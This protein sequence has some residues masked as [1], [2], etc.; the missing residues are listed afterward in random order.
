LL[1]LLPEALQDAD[2]ARLMRM[3]DRELVL[4]K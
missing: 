1:E 3:I 2:P 4:A